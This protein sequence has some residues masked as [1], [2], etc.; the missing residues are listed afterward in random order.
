MIPLVLLF[1]FLFLPYDKV[2]SFFY[3]YN[4][5]AEP[6][7][8]YIKANKGISNSLEG[9]SVKIHSYTVTYAFF[10]DGLNYEESIVLNTIPSNNKLITA[11]QL[12]KRSFIIVKYNG[13]NPYRS[14]LALD[15][16]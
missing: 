16:E 2:R 10:V 15:S 9:S 11:I 8:W 5:V 1:L 6:S 12:D 4:C 7:S 13:N 3:D 14:V